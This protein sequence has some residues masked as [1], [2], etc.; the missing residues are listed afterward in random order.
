MAFPTALSG[1]VKPSR[2]L[3]EPRFDIPTESRGKCHFLLL[4]LFIVKSVGSV[5]KEFP[6]AT[7]LAF[8]A[9]VASTHFDFDPAIKSFLVYLCNDEQIFLSVLKAMR[10][11]LDVFRATEYDGLFVACSLPSIIFQVSSPIQF[12]TGGT[13]NDIQ[14]PPFRSRTSRSESN[15]VT[16]QARQ[17]SS[18]F[19]PHSLVTMSRVSPTPP[20]SMS[21]DLPL[22]YTVQIILR[23]RA[24]QTSLG[25]SAC[26]PR[27]PL[28]ANESFLGLS[29]YPGSMTEVTSQDDHDFGSLGCLFFIIEKRLDGDVIRKR[30]VFD[31]GRIPR[32]ILA[33]DQELN[34]LLA[35]RNTVI[36]ASPSSLFTMQF[37][38][39]TLRYPKFE[40][41]SPSR[42]SLP[43]G[44]AERKHA[45]YYIPHRLD[46]KGI[47]ITILAW[48]KESYRQTTATL[49]IGNGQCMT[50]SMVTTS[51]A[52]VLEGRADSS[53]LER[54]VP[55]K[56]WFPILFNTPFVVNEGDIISLKHTATKTRPKGREIDFRNF[57]KLT[58]PRL[59]S[60]SSFPST[61]ASALKQQHNKKII[62]RLVAIRASRSMT[63]DPPEPLINPA[64]ESIV[65]KGLYNGSTH[66]VNS[67]L[68]PDFR[69]LGTI[70]WV[71]EKNGPVVEKDIEEDDPPAEKDVKKD[72]RLARKSIVYDT[73][74]IPIEVL[75]ADRALMRYLDMRASVRT[76]HGSAASN[77]S[78]QSSPARRMT[79]SVSSTPARHTNAS[80]PSTPARHTNASVPST[81]ARHTTA[82]VPS[83]LAHCTSAS[84]PPSASP[85]PVTP[86]LS[87][88]LVPS[89][90]VTASHNAATNAGPD[91]DDDEIEF[92]GFLHPNGA[93]LPDR[94]VRR[95]K[96]NTN[97]GGNPL[98]R[99]PSIVILSITVHMVVWAADMF[100]HRAVKVPLASGQYMRLSMVSDVLQR[101]G[102]DI[103]GELDRF[104][105]GVGWTPILMNTL[106]MVNDGDVVPL[107]S[108]AV[109]EIRDFEI[110]MTHLF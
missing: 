13:V 36:T 35:L 20:T 1:N 73:A 44:R 74:S 59:T 107:K 57:P 26:P 23:L 47:T 87:R 27:P 17:A 100:K 48:T 70:F 94:P 22:L 45:P 99:T 88:V 75:L 67:P 92:V 78:P 37:L 5:A 14:T 65:R 30:A 16:L 33:S 42:R 9:P 86:N 84:V 49:K 2:F 96:G 12:T 91:D 56:G 90:P 103:N 21:G 85:F 28:H 62:A 68:H 64:R 60:A 54:F 11:H 38:M 108:S 19:S 10:L 40:P 3:S 69:K 66:E 79:T 8:F 6:T 80:V 46:R 98:N 77:S 72:S 76:S 61:P 25:L 95:V 71:I 43:N 24:L 110:Q 97:S 93:V 52:E 15:Q 51:L 109:R 18:A 32:R 58:M 55:H 31:D 83:T 29:I 101:L 105:R 81:P 89:S 104:I 106:F 39:P 41:R 34:E 7:G 102:V 4:L 50:L 53:N 82:S 63:M